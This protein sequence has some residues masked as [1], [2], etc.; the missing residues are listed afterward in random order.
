MTEMIKTYLDQIK[1]GAEQSY[2]NLA[3][4]PL[5]SSFS[6]PCNC[7]PKNESLQNDIIEKDAIDKNRSNPKRKVINKSNEIVLISNGKKSA[8]VIQKRSINNTVLIPP[9]ETDLILEKCA[10]QNQSYCIPNRNYSNKRGTASLDY[11]EQF[12]RVDGQIGAIFLVNGKI[13]G[14]IYFDRP[15]IFE[16]SFIKIVECYAKK[17]VDKFDPKMDLRSSKPV[18]ISFLKTPVESGIEIQSA[19]G[20]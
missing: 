19:A 9:E 6:F 18:V 4:F 7:L 14:M 12:A 3:M 17:A 13:A 15:D 1:I 2:K 10:D 20:F 11:M 5:L 8:G 16:K